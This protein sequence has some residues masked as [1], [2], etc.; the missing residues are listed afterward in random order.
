MTM[1][2]WPRWATPAGTAS[3]TKRSTTA[4]PTSARDVAAAGASCGDG[5]SGEFVHNG[6][7]GEFWPRPAP[8][9]RT[10]ALRDVA[11][12]G[13]K[14]AAVCAAGEDGRAAPRDV[15][16]TGAGSAA[17]GTGVLPAWQFVCLL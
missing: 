7:A 4:T 10:S 15:A 9:A 16:A 13:V 5:R 12:A 8:A 2:T 17:V 14:L 1:Q 6:D 11:V 3:A